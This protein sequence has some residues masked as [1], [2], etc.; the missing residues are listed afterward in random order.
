L[1]VDIRG[2]TG[3]SVAIAY[4]FTAGNIG[5]GKTFNDDA[6]TDFT[7]E[8]KREALLKIK[9]VSILSLDH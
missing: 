8:D 9:P 4:G 5:K 2:D 1:E 7:N 6:Q 3:D